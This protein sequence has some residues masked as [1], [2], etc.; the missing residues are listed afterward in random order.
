MKTI[1]LARCPLNVVT[2]C[3]WSCMQCPTRLTHDVFDFVSVCMDVNCVDC[4][5]GC[6]GGVLHAWGF[7]RVCMLRFCACVRAQRQ[8]RIKT[9]RCAFFARCVN[10]GLTLL[11]L[12]SSI[13]RSIVSSRSSYTHSLLWMVREEVAHGVF[14]CDLEVSV[15]QRFTKEQL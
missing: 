15:I 4:M 12:P 13:I 14:F 3:T 5:G 2:C 8:Q 6:M 11:L 10:T 1:V 7:A 9:A